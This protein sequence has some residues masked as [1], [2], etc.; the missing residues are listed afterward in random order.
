M[1]NSNT[2]EFY[3]GRRK[4]KFPPEEDSY[5]GSSQTWYKTLS[6]N[7]IKSL[8]KEII[9][10]FDSSEE[11]CLS[12]INYISESIKNPL[13]RNY[14][15]P[16][17]GFYCKG[18]NPETKE[19]MKGKVLVRDEE[20]KALKI[21]R[22]DERYTSGI[23]YG[24]NKNKVIV[25]NKEGKTLSVDKNDER[26]INGDLVPVS[27]DMVTVRNKEG[28]TVQI[29][30]KDPNY[31]NGEYTHIAT[32][33]TPWNKGNTPIEEY[34]D[35]ILIKTWPNLITLHEETKIP[36]SSIVNW[37]NK[38]RNNNKGIT[39]KYQSKNN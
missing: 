30:K 31:L 4:S 14:H 35:G 5:M 11:M 6:K 13:C 15:I 25:R 2:G 7:D 18:H 26:Y 38:K 20:G 21:D 33:H 17:K 1:T 10:V 22:E 37:I 27:K 29:S 16:G 3:I 34:K 32:G 8:N 36:K 39:Y 23:L 24:I 19:K 12:E 9:K 28:K